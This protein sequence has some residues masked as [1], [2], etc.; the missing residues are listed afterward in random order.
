MRA[1]YEAGPGV[2]TY[3]RPLTM[4]IPVVIGRRED[5]S[6]ACVLPTVDSVFQCDHRKS[7]EENTKDHV[8]HIL[9]GLEP[10]E[11]SRLLMSKHYRLD[12]V[13]VSARARKQEG[14]KPGLPT[15]HRIA[16]PFGGASM[17]RKFSGVWRRDDE[18]ATVARRLQ[19]R[20]NLLLVGEG[21]VG[22]TAVLVSAIRKLEQLERQTSP[23]ADDGLPWMAVVRERF[24]LTSGAHI[25]AGMKYLGQ[26][27]ERCERWSGSWTRSPACCAST[28]CWS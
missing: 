18:I 22:K 2:R 5:G 4:R 25:V 9:D 27:Q 13:I 6:F 14:W 19:K 28:T 8:R 21:G 17:R 15:L 10:R 1:G 7:V 3:D 24:W 11:L 20:A 26:W 12:A 23:D 16:E